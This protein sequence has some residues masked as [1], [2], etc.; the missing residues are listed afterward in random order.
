MISIVALLYNYCLFLYNIIDNYVNID[1]V[2][3]TC[4]VFVSDSNI[5]VPSISSL[6][7]LDNISQC[8]DDPKPKNK[9][10]VRE[11]FIL[12]KLILFTKLLQFCR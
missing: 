5:V 12:P 7:S 11:C 2:N 4:F 8:S 10:N 6:T 3:N 1:L 9:G